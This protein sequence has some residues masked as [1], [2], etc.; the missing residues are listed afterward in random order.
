[1]KFRKFESKSSFMRN[2]WKRTA[3]SCECLACRPGGNVKIL[4]LPIVSFCF[5]F[6][7]L[8]EQV[9]ILRL[10]KPRYVL[11]P[12]C[13]FPTILFVH[14]IY[15]NER[16]FILLMR[17]EE[18]IYRRFVRVHKRICKSSSEC[19]RGKPINVGI[20]RWPP[21]AHLLDSAFGFVTVQQICL[22]AI[23]RNYLST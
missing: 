10:I 22:T 21:E 4:H 11:P 12:P 6:V 16:E 13:E 18:I 2:L 20:P 7:Q 3:S 5:R 23:F 19:T 15:I 14:L 8:R 9:A 1:M 17:R